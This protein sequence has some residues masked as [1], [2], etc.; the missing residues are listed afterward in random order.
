MFGVT[1]SDAADLAGIVTGVA[2]LVLSLVLGL[3]AYSQYRGASRRDVGAELTEVLT[4]LSK[5]SGGFWIGDEGTRTAFY[6]EHG[7]AARYLAFR[8]DRLLAELPAS[9]LNSFELGMIAQAFF[10]NAENDKADDYFDEAFAVAFASPC[11]DRSATLPVRLSLL[12]SRA[13]CMFALNRRD[14]GVALYERALALN[15][16]ADMGS[17]AMIEADIWATVTWSNGEFGLANTEFAEALLQR[18]DAMVLKLQVP[19][20]RARQ[21]NL[22]A[23]VRAW[24]A[25]M[26]AQAVERPSHGDANAQTGPMSASS[27]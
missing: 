26:A 24:R 22:V 7:M 10:L 14:E 11:A 5:L 6:Q 23:Q 12:R 27:P 17:D 19:W 20:R 16:S 3:Q 8:A 1:L 2:A 15:G 13:D 18:A 25:Q 9:D 4:E 21:Q